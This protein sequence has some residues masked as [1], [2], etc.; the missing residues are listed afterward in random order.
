MSKNIETGKA[1]VLLADSVTSV[2]ADMAFIDVQ[3][4]FDENSFPVEIADERCVSIDVLSPLSCRIELRINQ[5][6]RDKIVENLFGGDPDSIQKKNGEDSILEMLNII[7]GSFLSAY[8]GA[9]TEIQLE[10][11]Q[12]QYF[13]EQPQGQNVAKVLMLAENEPLTITLNSVRYRY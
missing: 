1:S 8:F 4:V 11:P 7:T 12:Y 13:N 3:E 6:L 2:F 5:A 10:L 9:G